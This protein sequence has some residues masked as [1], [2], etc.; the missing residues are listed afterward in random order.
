MFKQKV[1]APNGMVWTV[2]CRWP[3][4]SVQATREGAYFYTSPMR[5]RERES[6]LA[7]VI[8]AIESGE[9]DAALAERR[10]PKLSDGGELE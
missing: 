9:L 7:S 3:G 10:T 8:D 1:S 5:R 2:R 4:W 6:K